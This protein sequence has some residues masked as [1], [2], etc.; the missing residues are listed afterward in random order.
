MHNMKLED[1]KAYQK[2]YYAGRKRSVYSPEWVEHQVRLLQ[3]E[4]EMLV[5]KPKFVRRVLAK[6]KDGDYY[7]MKILDVNVTPDGTEVIIFK[8]PSSA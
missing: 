8:E 3:K 6:D 7:V 4:G 2:G 1:K 5:A